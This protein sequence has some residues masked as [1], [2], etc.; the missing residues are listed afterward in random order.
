MTDD[1]HGGRVRR[2]RISAG[3]SQTELGKLLSIPTTLV[4]KIEN[5]RHPA[6][7]SLARNLIER[8]GCSVELLSKPIPETLYTR[9]W[10][11]AYT[12]ASKRRVDQ[13]I[14]DTLLAVE[15]IQSMKLRLMPD[16]L[17]MFDDDP[18]DDRAIEDYAEE[19]RHAADIA[20]GGVVRN[21][22]RAVERLGCIVLPMADELG[23]HLGLS[24]RVDDIPA[25]RVARPRAFPGLSVA[26]DR[27]RFTTVHELGH[28]ALH[29]SMP[30]PETALEAKR[31]ENQAN[32]FAGAF[33]TPAE[34]LLG[35]LDALG[36]R[37]TLNT[38]A[39]LKQRWGVAIKALVIRFRELGLIDED[40]ARSLYKQISARGWNTSEPID[41]GQERAVW[42]SKAISKTFGD[43]GAEA[44][45]AASGLP[46]SRVEDWLNWEPLIVR[47]DGAKVI[48]LQTRGAGPHVAFG[49]AATVT[50]LPI[51]PRR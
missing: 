50:H 1:L 40:H 34:P 41:V 32:R 17:P 10:L 3:L 24:M 21:A 44:F 29:A 37:A 20:V 45:A 28:L 38:L 5:D 19:V 13:Y 51:R 39:H 42:F 31:I 18:D 46:L 4:S 36:G 30:P 26:G 48:Q 35:D 7:S 16:L 6:D 43:G 25:V 8:F 23:R 14:E 22:T 27:Q 47:P 15:A 33:L 49:D 12:D 11:R 9:P 2:L